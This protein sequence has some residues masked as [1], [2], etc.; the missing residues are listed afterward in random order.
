M[1][2]TNAGDSESA[3]QVY[4][5]TPTANRHIITTYLTENSINGFTPSYL[6]CCFINW[7]ARLAQ[8]LRDGTSK[9]ED[10]REGE[11]QVMQMLRNGFPVTSADEYLES[12]KLYLEVIAVSNQLKTSGELSAKDRAFG[13]LR[14][15][16]KARY[17]LWTYVFDKAE[18]EAYKEVYGVEVI[19]EIVP[20]V[21]W[22]EEVAKGKEWGG[23]VVFGL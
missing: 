3:L 21:D 14:E 2:D 17:T 8:H 7:A 11:K 13:R 12:V 10:L 19:R 16:L 18:K 1:A 22:R 6:N 4:Y 9:H 20:E 5:Y 23:D 15:V